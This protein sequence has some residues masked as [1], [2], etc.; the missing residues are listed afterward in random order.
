MQKVVGVAFNKKGRIYNFNANNFDLN[1]GDTVIVETEKGYQYGF[2]V[3]NI[4]EIDENEYNLPLKNVVRLTSKKDDQNYFKNNQDAGKAL[5]KAREIVDEL[6]LDMHIMDASY[7]FDRKQLLFNFTADDRI[8]F[9]ELAKRLAAI[10]K[11]RIELRQIG[12]RDKAR[13]VGGLGPCGRML[14]CN[15]FLTDLNGVTINMA[16]NQMLALN[17]TKINGSCGRLLCCLSYE[18]IVY[19]KL[20]ENL[21]DIGE[22]YSDKTVSGKV[23][24]LD[25]LGQKIYVEDKEGNVTIVEKNN[26]NN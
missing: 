12:V 19:T 3:T 25:I 16:K 8:D 9:R 24:D 14:C 2:V 11:T 7:T 18:D 6:K 22:M 1:I 13:E 17:P 15:T 23:V 26:G 10:Y 4:K 21:P 20:R 5:N